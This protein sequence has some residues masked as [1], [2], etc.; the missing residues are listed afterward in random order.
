[1]LQATLLGA[2]LAGCNQPAV[3]PNS[4]LSD[5]DLRWIARLAYG[6]D[7]NTLA[8]YRTLGRERFLDAQLKNSD[9][10]IAGLPTPPKDPARVLSEVGAA[11]KQLNAMPDGAD[12]EQARKALNEQGNQ[13]AYEASRRHLLRAINSPAQLQE[14]MTWF[15]LNHFS[16]FEYKANLRWLVG[17]YE[18]RAIRPHVFGHF[19]DLVM[20]TLAHPAMLQYLDN[21]QN[22]AGHINE[23]FARELMELHTLGV[24]G[25]YGQRDVQALARILTGVGVNAGAQPALRREWQALYRRDGA[26]EFNP[27]RH[28]FGTK[29]FLGRT[30]HGSGFAEV[31]QAVD[32]LVKQS[33]CAHFISRQLAMYFVA[34]DPPA[35]LVERMAGTFAATDGDIAAVLRTM[36]LSGE[37]AGSLGMKFKDPMQYVISAVRLAYDARPI[38][39]AHPIVNWLGALGEPLYGRQTPDGYPLVEGGWAS[40]G[41]M[42]RRFEIARAI[43][44]GN[45]GLFEPEDGSGATSSGFPR[46]SS[47]VYFDAVEPL[48]SAQTRA[49]LDRTTSQ[50]EW[51]TVLLASPEFNYR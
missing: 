30:I 10:A 20:A 48:L 50:A 17:D 39:N 11:Y 41:Q 12:K 8:Q 3:K 49:V 31:E 33:A 13:A 7:S 34:D 43:G 23:N 15:W 45:S 6:V 26:F 21:A 16:V 36:F 37:A 2:L 51:N 22:A 25:G 14:Q 1:V 19:R 29:I 28:D 46:L 47:R 35:Q 44:A 9:P 5:T 24:Q 27:A 4:G 42:S 40:S 38:A 18:E 32:L